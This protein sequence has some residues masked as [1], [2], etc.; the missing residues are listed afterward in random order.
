[1]PMPSQDHTPA[2]ERTVNPPGNSTAP[3]MEL[4]CAKPLREDGRVKVNLPKEVAEEGYGEW[5]FTNIGY[6]IG[7]IWG[8][9]V[10]PCQILYRAKTSFSG[11]ELNCS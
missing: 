1:M 2:D 7:Q 11:R 8:M 5:L 4:K 6:F 3:L 9:A 10:H